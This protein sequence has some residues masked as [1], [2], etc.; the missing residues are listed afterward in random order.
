M[1]AAEELVVLIVDIILLIV[2][3][4]LENESGTD[5]PAARIAALVIGVPFLAGFITEIVISGAQILEYLLLIGVNLAFV[6]YVY[7]FHVSENA[8]ESKVQEQ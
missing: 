7:S 4:K 6:A 3:K 1:V 8:N 5:H 2:M